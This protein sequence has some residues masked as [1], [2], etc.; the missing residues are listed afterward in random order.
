MRSR[1]STQHSLS[2][3]LS[4]VD[5]SQRMTKLRLFKCELSQTNSEVCEVLK[6]LCRWVREC[7]AS[8]QIKKM[9]YLRTFSLCSFLET[10]VDK[11]VSPHGPFISCSGSFD[12]I[13]WSSPADGVFSHAGG[14]ALVLFGSDW[15]ISTSLPWIA[16]RFCTDIQSPKS[17]NPNDIGD[18]P[19]FPLGTPRGCVF[20]WNNCSM[21]CYSIWYTE[22]IPR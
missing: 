2:L 22:M 18:P 12:H 7:T 8:F 20:E 19:T 5:G 15:N 11:T 3:S 10:A 21:D 17:I 9:I 1:P 14:V 16:M 13:A 6:I 4:S